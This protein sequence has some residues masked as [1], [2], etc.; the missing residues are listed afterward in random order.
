MIIETHTHSLTHTPQ[1]SSCWWWVHH[2]LSRWSWMCTAPTGIH[3]ATDRWPQSPKNREG[4]YYWDF[5]I[6]LPHSHT[7]T[8]QPFLVHGSP[9]PPE[10]VVASQSLSEECHWPADGTHLENTHDQFYKMTTSTLF[11]WGVCKQNPP[12]QRQDKD[13]A[14]T[15]FM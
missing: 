10:A 4:E 8:P 14:V 2:I 5:S 15:S 6:P 3:T 13:S 9:C 7:H 12:R 1:G 11:Y